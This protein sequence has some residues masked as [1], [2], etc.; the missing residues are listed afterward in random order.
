MHIVYFIL[1]LLQNYHHNKLK[2]GYIFNAIGSLIGSSKKC[3]FFKIGLQRQNG[4]RQ[5]C[6]GERRHQQ[7]QSCPSLFEESG[8]TEHQRT[9]KNENLFNSKSG[10]N[11]TATLG[12]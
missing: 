5:A 2:N 6:T 12:R 8:P 7:E 1:Q 4:K 11:Q 3:I 9:E 10:R